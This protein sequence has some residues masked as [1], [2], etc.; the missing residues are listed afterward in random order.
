MKVHVRFFGQVESFTRHLSPDQLAALPAVEL[1]DGA[2]ISDL[3][4]VLRVTD[5][6]GSV[7][8]FVSVN[9][10]YQRDDVVLHDGDR[11]ELVPPMAGGQPIPQLDTKT[12]SSRVLHCPVGDVAVLLVEG[13]AQQDDGLVTVS[14]GEI[15]LL[16][17][18]LL[19]GSDWRR[20]AVS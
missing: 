20:F 17:S 18:N 5:T 3:L 6:P 12:A 8:P 14:E 15:V 4:Q 1:P 13:N 16:L 7:R 9:G 11:V 2:R 10:V 19:N